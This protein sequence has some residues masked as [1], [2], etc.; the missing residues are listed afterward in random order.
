MLPFGL[1]NPDGL[2]LVLDEVDKKKDKDTQA[3]LDKAG[4]R[5]PDAPSSLSLRS[6]INLLSGL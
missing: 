5:Q 1:S 4:D 2:V 6:Y 3:L